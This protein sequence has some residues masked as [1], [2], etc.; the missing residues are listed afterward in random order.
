MQLMHTHT[1][2][3]ADE[4]DGESRSTCEETKIPEISHM[5]SPVRE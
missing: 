1:L 2:S 3:K 5:L 4:L